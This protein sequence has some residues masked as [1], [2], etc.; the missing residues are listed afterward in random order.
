MRHEALPFDPSVCQ[1]V[2]IGRRKEVRLAL[3]PVALVH[4]A[5]TKA[6]V[7]GVSACQAV[8]TIKCRLHPGLYWKLISMLESS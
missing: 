1:Q 7:L 4:G 8:S 5:E 3:E 2:V 6:G